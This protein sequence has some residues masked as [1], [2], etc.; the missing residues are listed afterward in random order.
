MSAAFELH[1][2]ATDRW[3]SPINSPGAQVVIA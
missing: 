1:G 3:I 2:L